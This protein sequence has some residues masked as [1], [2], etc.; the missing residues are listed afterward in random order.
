MIKALYTISLPVLG[1]IT[2]KALGRRLFWC[3]WN[4]WCWGVLDTN[5]TFGMA[6]CVGLGVADWVGGI[7]PVLGNIC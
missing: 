4:G 5:D 6:A 2:A 7:G 3:L 1:S